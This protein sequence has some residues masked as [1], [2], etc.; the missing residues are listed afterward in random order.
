[1]SQKEQY[2]DL[3]P[4]FNAGVISPDVAN[5]TDLDKFRL[6]LLQARNCFI[7][8]YGAVYRRPGTRFVAETKY[9]DK[10]SILYEFDYNAKISYLLEIGVGYIRVYKDDT[11]L[12]I[13]VTTPF[14]EDD[15]ENL[16]FAQSADT[17]FIA[18]GTHNVQLFQ[19]FT[20]TNWKL[21]EMDLT[22]PYFDVTNGSSG[23]DGLPSVPDVIQVDQTWRT[24]GNFTFTAPAD[25]E[26]TVALFGGGGGYATYVEQTASNQWTHQEKNGGGWITVEDTVAVGEGGSGEYKTVKMTLKKGQTYS[27]SVG[28]V[29]YCADYWKD[30]MHNWND[31]PT[32]GKGG[33]ASFN[34]VTAQGGGGGKVNVHEWH[35]E[36]EQNG[37]SYNPPGGSGGTVDLGQ[38]EDTDF[39]VG[40]NKGTVRRHKR[41]APQAPWV[42]I[43]FNNNAG[44]QNFRTDGLSPSG[45]TGAITITST[46]DVFRSGLVGGCIKLYHDMPAQ[47]VSQW[48]NKYTVSGYILVGK[49]WHVVTHGKWGGTV[50]VQSSRDS[51]TWHDFR[52]YTSNYT[53][54]NGDFNASESGTVDDYMFMRVVA[55]IT[56]GSCTVDL[57]R[58]PYTHEGHAI[59]TGVTDAKKVKANVVKQFGSTE[60]TNLFAFSCWNPEYGYPRCVAFFQ[61]RLVL[62]ANKLYPFAVWMSRSGDY[63]NFSVEKADGKVTDDSAIMLSLV[64]RKEYNIRHLVAFTDLIIFTDGNEW[65]IS[66]ANTVTPTQI[67]PR[68]Q[69]SRGCEDA[70]PQLVGGR[71]VYVQRRGTVV[72]DFAYSFDTDN[73]D[74]A[75]LTILAKHLTRDCILVQA[76]YEQDPNSMM[77]FTTSRGKINCLAYVAD[78]KVYAWSQLDTTGSFESVCNVTNGERD[79]IY[80]VVKRTVGG[81]EKRFIEYF[82]DY[83]DS[84]EIMDYTMLDCAHMVENSSPT[85]KAGGLGDLSGAEVVA[86]CDG[87]VYKGVTISES[88][89]LELPVDFKTGIVGFPYKTEIELPN[90]DINS[91]GGTVQGKFKKV[92]EAI[93]KLTRSLGGEIGNSK[94]FTD[95]MPYPEE[96]ALFTGDLV[97]T[98]PNEPTGGYE[99]QG[100]IYIK[101]DDPYPFDMASIIR[102][103]TF[104]G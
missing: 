70:I 76:A 90:V 15:L 59:I 36:N 52:R 3:Q 16:K 49:G 38:T 50:I 80:T 67:N 33:N 94:K 10:K 71:I 103:V 77:F 78:Q 12:G 11:Y 42:R 104:G 30:I 35:Y 96:N 56:A 72:R 2:Y 53:D 73:Y 102:V 45:L 17:L 60:K 26:Y 97:V 58:N 61:D 8:P 20:D 84:D 82:T 92:S 13:E 51:Q 66:G 88:G 54:G 74:G 95:T 1:M 40:A 81:K 69:S 31:D 75:D 93:L 65:L 63:Y 68:V 7:R 46:S 87:K 79:T 101:T 25:G 6:A 91:K 89:N 99:K 21:S 22:N 28:S 5:R 43:T 27:G 9:A 41:I 100:R 47:T 14:T 18:S 55:D 23:L 86:V 44:A 32:G 62:A 83:P 37:T 85:N 4:A 48:A 29:G 24:P 64:N 19:R 57:T 34:G 98:V 39:K